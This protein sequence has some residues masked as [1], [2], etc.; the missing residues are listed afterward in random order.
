MKVFWWNMET[1]YSGWWRLSATP[2]LLNENGI[3]ATGGEVT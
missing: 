2:P 1:I 3:A